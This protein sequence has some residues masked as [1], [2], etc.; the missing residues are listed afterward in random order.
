VSG[1]RVKI[2]GPCKPSVT[3][4]DKP[5][6]ERMDAL[7]RDCAPFLRDGMFSGPEVPK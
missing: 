1:A 2:K 6:N 3:R 7:L 5:I 4:R